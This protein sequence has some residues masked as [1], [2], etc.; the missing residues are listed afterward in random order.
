MSQNFDEAVSAELV[1]LTLGGKPERP[2]LEYR[3]ELCDLSELSKYGCV[4]CVDPTL[5]NL[6]PEDGGM[7]ADEEEE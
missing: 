5:R 7:W 6:G 1:R 3:D 2:E 4:H